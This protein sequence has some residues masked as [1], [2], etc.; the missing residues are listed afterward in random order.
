MPEFNYIIIIIIHCSL[1]LA[2]KTGTILFVF[3]LGHESD[4]VFVVLPSSHS[5]WMDGVETDP[6]KNVR[7]HS[8]AS[9]KAA[10]YNIYIRDDRRE[11]EMQKDGWMLCTLHCTL[12]RSF[13][14]W[15]SSIERSIGRR[16]LHFIHSL[17]LYCGTTTIRAQIKCCHPSSPAQTVQSSSV[18][19]RG[20][21]SV[22]WGC[23][24]ILGH[25][26]SDPF[27]VLTFV[28]T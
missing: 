26:P 11:R 12:S 25:C 22:C 1:L 9:I 19:R 6:M 15:A 27:Y 20:L 16:R 5:G 23:C 10:P 3:P 28:H 14:L 8:R 17:A 2:K 4:R 24:G 21:T 13:G 7:V 18:D